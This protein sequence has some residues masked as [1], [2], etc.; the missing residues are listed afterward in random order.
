[1]EFKCSACEYTSLNKFCA[2]RHI[3]KMKK[4]GENPTVIII[5]NSISCEYCGTECKTIR[6]MTDH[7]KICKIF[8]NAQLETSTTHTSTA[9]VLTKNILK[10]VHVPLMSYYDPK[11]PDNID[12]IC[13]E[14]W[15]KMKCVPTYIKRIYFDTNIPENHSIC[16]SNLR[17]V[18]GTKI[19]DG[20]KWV[21]AG[22]NYIISAII[23]DVHS[24]L[25]KW[26]KADKKRSK[27][28]KA[29]TKY[30]ADIA[31]N[32]GILSSNDAQERSELK[33]LLYQGYVEGKVNTKSTTAVSICAGPN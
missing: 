29:Y 5:N 22:T 3:T 7:Y 9:H 23:I 19:Y 30:I 16:I 33:A 28:L 6:T 26:V 13:E 21:V 25:D 2:D 15:R 11:I 14:A 4:C 32:Q 24:I 8:K 20:D 10:H 17:A 12:N 31:E 18:L 27:Y 1:M